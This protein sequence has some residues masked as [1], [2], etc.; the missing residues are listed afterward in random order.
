M[1]REN[2]LRY[3]ADPSVLDHS[4]IQEVQQLADTFPWFQ[5]AHLL[6]VKNHHNIDSLGFHDALKEAAAYTGDRAVMYHLIHGMEKEV[7]LQARKT[8]ELISR[9]P[10]DMVTGKDTLDYGSGYSIT[11]TKDPLKDAMYIK[12]YTFT[13]W[14]DQIQEDIQ[15][16]KERFET[17]EDIREKSETQNLIDRFINERPNIVPMV[18]GMTDSRDMAE[19][20]TRNSDAFITET[21]AKIYV[22][23]GLYKKAINVYEKLS[24]KY[25]EKNTYFAQQIFR[26]RSISD[27]N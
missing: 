11:D 20:S 3:V 15:G 22:K 2:I 7:S 27:K 25:P 24:L 6:L 23:Q 17:G 13:G 1:K 12:E 16:P 26:I 10:D 8:E 5:T 18:T 19:G 14:F 4:S 21:L 9:L